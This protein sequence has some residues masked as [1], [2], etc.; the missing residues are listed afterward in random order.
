M[1]EAAPAT[2]N[3]AEPLLTVGMLT[4]YFP[5]GGSGLL[6]GEVGRSRPLTA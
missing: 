6:G 3:G 1:T 4:K 5:V 2:N